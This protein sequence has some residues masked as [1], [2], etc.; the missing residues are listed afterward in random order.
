M[1]NLINIGLSGLQAQQVAITT[2]GQNVSNA[3]TDGYSRQRAIF[4]ANVPQVTGS[5]YVGSGVNILDIQR[6]NSQFANTQ[7]RSDTSLFNEQDTLLTQLNQLDNL[8]GS[9]ST[10][11]SSAMQSFFNALQSASTDPASVAQR[12]AVL[13]QAQGLASRFHSL[14][15]QFSTQEQSVNQ[16]L[17]SNV[18][19]VNTLAKDIAQLNAAIASAPGR[20][21][22]HEPNDLLDQRDEKI[23]QLSE[24]VK[25]QVSDQGDGQVNVTVGNGQALV[26][27][28]RANP[29]SLVNDPSDASKQQV[30]I[31]TNSGIQIIS[32]DLSG[33]KLGGVL[34]YRD[35]VL[36][37]A[38]NSLG[39]IAISLSS[40]FNKQHELGM[41]LNG[42]LGG[43]FFNDVNDPTAA[44]QRVISNAN[45]A[46]PDDRVLSVKITDANKLSTNNY[47][48]E[49]N[50]PTNNDYVIRNAADGSILSQGTLTGSF[51]ASIEMPG[52][53]I[54]L[55][56]GSFQQGDKFLVRPTYTGARD[57]GV[58]INN[59]DQIALAAPIQGQAELS[60]QGTGSISQG[61]MLDLNNPLTNKP[62]NTLTD[63][64]MTPPLMVRFVTPTTYE[65]LD[66]TDPANPKPLQPPMNN[67]TYQ[68]GVTN[69]LFTAD[70]GQT[71]VSMAGTALNQTGNATDNGYGAQNITVRT[72]DATTGQVTQQ[73]ISIAAGSS[74]QQIA[75]QLQTVSGVQA[76][77]YTEVK[78]SNFTDNGDASTPSLT[79]NGE[80]FNFTAPNT[81]GPDAFVNQI[82]SD[83]NLQAAGIVAVSDGQNLTLRSTTGADINV[84][85]GG[86][87]DSVDVQKLNPY[88]N[89][90]PAA[91]TVTSGN[92]I[93]TGGYVD[94]SMA[95]G[96]SLVA[97]NN[98]LF[99]QAPVAQNSYRG[100]QFQISG[101]PSAGDVFDIGYN[102]DGVSDNRNALA[103]A[104]LQ[105][106]KTMGNS[107]S[108]YS[109]S[110]SQ[111]V[112][113]V[114]TRTSQATLD[115]SSSKALLS[116]SQSQWQSISGVNLDEEAG[117]LI[118]YQAAY[119]ASAKVV[120]IARQLF[121]TLINTFQ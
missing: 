78:L 17:S 24:L 82:N 4:G 21:Q 38:I 66:A 109:D 46:Q 68:P 76:S 112:E 91:T 77:A 106:Q 87:G 72:R 20:A 9:N 117:K 13:S 49:F 45:N 11:L 96:V 23:R 7:L 42:K 27:N 8:L 51:P 81:F 40:N 48:L 114:G 101:S 99:N 98:N 10:G 58:Q 71:S 1:A 100:Y 2:T 14:Y 79:I 80:T 25:V 85:V 89:A 104:G 64:K 97:N 69:T 5:G 33:G 32:N 75:T 93:V 94:L 63:G 115:Q 53:E 111:L 90:S 28:D 120:S 73:S 107:T 54:N 47:S 105:T 41:D 44:G 95:N 52:F 35:Q 119:N 83:A 22:G 61:T 84:A 113:T 31:S 56:S 34:Q 36:E 65:V 29:L 74:A 103:L 18:S 50:G 19:R 60:N 59:I 6:Q 116:Q 67:L 86:G 88:G 70:P 62:L 102:T 92:N 39:G 55:T 121:D 15:S 12:Q 108:S 26:I 30:A 118:Q 43:L 37:P 57:F 110:Y 16:Q 3:N